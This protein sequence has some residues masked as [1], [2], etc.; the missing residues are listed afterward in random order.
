MGL[1]EK[2]LSPGTS[3]TVKTETFLP[4]CAGRQS[5][6]Y[7]RPGLTAKWAFQASAGTEIGP[8]LNPPFT[9]VAGRPAADGKGAGP[10]QAG[11]SQDAGDSPLA[12][13]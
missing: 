2:L 7:F 6:G 11:S 5:R 12:G 9:N 3:K 4:R 13:I 1:L 10:Q 8:E